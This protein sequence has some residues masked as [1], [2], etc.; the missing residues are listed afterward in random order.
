MPLEKL[1]P[2]LKSIQEEKGDILETKFHKYQFG[3]ASF[4]TYF[5]KDSSLLRLE[6]DRSFNISGL[7]FS[8]LANKSSTK[9]EEKSF[10]EI[11][12][13]ISTVNLPKPNTI[14]ETVNSITVKTNTSVLKKSLILDYLL[15]ENGL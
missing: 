12:D 10:L 4:K 3:W 2:L 8:D 5:E 14:S 9:K 7:K 15:K 11:K 1:S 6:V 13:T